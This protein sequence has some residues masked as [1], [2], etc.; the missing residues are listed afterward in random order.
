MQEKFENEDQWASKEEVWQLLIVGTTSI[1]KEN[2]MLPQDQFWELTVD[3]M[4]RNW[5]GHGCREQRER[6]SLH[7]VLHP[8]RDCILAIMQLPQAGER[9]CKYKI[10][11]WMD[12]L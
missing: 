2:N 9:T 4:D 5:N 12:G 6:R 10:L 8:I 11:S 1:W 7:R 3:Q